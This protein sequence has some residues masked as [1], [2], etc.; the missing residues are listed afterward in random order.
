MEFTR[1]IKFIIIVVINIKVINLRI[2]S[3]LPV[4]IISGKNC[5]L[6]NKSKLASFGRRCF[7]VTGKTSARTSGALNDILKIFA[8]SDTDYFIFDKIEP[9]PLTSTCKLAGDKAREF[10]ADYILGIGGGSA[11][12][13]AKAIAIFCSNPHFDHTDIYNRTLPAKKLPVVLI[14]TTAGTGSEVTGVSVLTNS[15]TGIKKSISGKDCYADVAFCDYSYTKSAN[16]EIRISTMLDALAHAVESYFASSSNDLVDLYAL[17][18]VKIL[19]S[20]IIN[21]DFNSLDDRDFEKLYIASIYAGMAINIAG[22]CFPHTVGYYLTENF[23]IPHGRACAVFMPEF[24]NRAKKYCPEK[25]EAIEVCFGVGFD[26]F[27]DSLSKLNN[28][29]IDLCDMN[30]E[31]LL[32]RWKGG[33]KN[34]D[35]TPGGFNEYDAVGAIRKII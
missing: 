34:F 33:I 17:K 9:N 31:L 13:A 32:S 23:D 27:V 4:E 7:I 26:S 16:N 3:Y 20:Y 29:K 15:E 18:A 25:V 12:D 21:S 2:D 24:L 35:R 1:E 19:S 10:N 8:E 22:T 30:E 5:L 6:D 28:L 11:L 14:G